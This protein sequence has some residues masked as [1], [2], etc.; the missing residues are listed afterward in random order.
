MSSQKNALKS[1]GHDVSHEKKLSSGQQHEVDRAVNNF[2]KA[3]DDR[4]KFFND[5]FIKKIKE[6]N[7]KALLELQQQALPPTQMDLRPEL[8]KCLKSNVSD[9]HPFSMKDGKLYTLLELKRLVPEW[10]SIAEKALME[11]DPALAD[12][13]MSPAQWNAKCAFAVTFVSA[14][15]ELRD[16]KKTKQ[17]S[18][19][20]DHYMKWI[21]NPLHKAIEAVAAVNPPGNSL[22][23]YGDRISLSEAM[24][25]ARNLR[26]EFQKILSEKARS[27][28]K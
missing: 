11:S 7:R 23:G 6:G 12:K 8:A 16:I 22:I 3:Y 19:D 27:T 21:I 2:I 1:Q 17:T 18:G 13:L 25:A 26:N 15:N 14:M 20:F 9:G 5:V 10:S 28:M 24:A 4:A